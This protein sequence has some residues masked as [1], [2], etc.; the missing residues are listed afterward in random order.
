ME[1]DITSEEGTVFGNAYYQGELFFSLKTHIRCD[2]D[3][4]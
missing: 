4:W 2:G 1:A 3:G